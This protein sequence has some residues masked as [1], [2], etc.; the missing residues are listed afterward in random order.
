MEELKELI[1]K[2]EQQE[3]DLRTLNYESFSAIHQSMLMGKH[4]AI[5]II[6]AELKKV[7]DKG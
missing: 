4:L 3:N 5:L 2:F 1:E 7:L 6:I